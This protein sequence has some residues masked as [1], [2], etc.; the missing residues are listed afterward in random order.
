MKQSARSA[1]PPGGTLA[2]KLIDTLV[3]VATLGAI[4]IGVSIPFAIRVSPYFAVLTVP[5]C[6]IPVYLYEKF[7][8]SRL[9]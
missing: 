5:A 6:L 3:G 9:H 7:L 4:L 8:R 2:G 1:S